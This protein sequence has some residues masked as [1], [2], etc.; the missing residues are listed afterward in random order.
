MCPEQFALTLSGYEHKYKYKNSIIIAVTVQVVVYQIAF[1]GGGGGGGGR[2]RCTQ[3]LILTKS[4]MPLVYVCQRACSDK[5]PW[6][7]KDRWEVIKISMTFLCVLNRA[8]KDASCYLRN[9]QLNPPFSVIHFKGEVLWYFYPWCLY[10]LK[11]PMYQ[12]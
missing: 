2:S 5:E 8:V 1:S 3:P 7:S 12:L 9:E 11:C 4:W 6:Y 10:A